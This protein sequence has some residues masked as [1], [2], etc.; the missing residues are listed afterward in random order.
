MSSGTL[1]RRDLLAGLGL[2]VARRPAVAH[3][4]QRSGTERYRIGA[5]DWSIGRRGQVE[6]LAQGRAL[7]LDGVQVSMGSVDDDLRL[8]RPDVQ[9]AYLE[10]AAEHGIRI[11]GV[12][13]DVMNRVPYKSDPRTIQWVIDSIDVAKAL[14]VGVILL[15]FFEQGDLRD[16]AAGQAEVARRL[17]EAAPRAEAQGVV[18]G[19]ESWLSAPEHIRLLDAVGS[20][21]VQVY[22]D[23]ANSHHMGYDIYAEI[24]QLGHARVCEIHA[25]ENGSL[26][27]QGSIDFRQV[28]AALDDIGFS[29]WLQIEGSVPKGQP[30]IESYTHNVQFMRQTF[31]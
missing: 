24:R 7:G 25:K 22:Y 19:I 9:R 13:L 4:W 2:A 26:L 11:G 14:G 18:L 6:A 17:K 20:P 1:S 15:A 28:R 29:G 5:C 27:G 8:R 10:A 12:A 30:V 3:A 16:D 31:G 21:S 23:V